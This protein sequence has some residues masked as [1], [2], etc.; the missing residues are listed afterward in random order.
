MEKIDC[1]Y[2]SDAS[3]IKGKL[4]SVKIPD[5]IE[6]VQKIIKKNNKITI[7]GA[8]TGLVGGC[9]PENSIVL[10]LSKF[11]NIK[12]FENNC[13]WVETGVVLDDLN[14]FLAERNFEFPIN[15]S[16]HSVCTIG[17][18]IANNAAGSRAFVYGKTL[19]WISELKVILTG[20][21]IKIIKE[22]DIKDFCSFEGINGVIIEAKLKLSPL[23]KRTISLLNFDSLQEILNKTKEL[24]K[25]KDVSKIE[26]W[27][28]KTS[29]ILKLDKKYF[30]LIEFESE[31]GELSEIK[32][33]E[34]NELRDSVYPRLAQAGFSKIED[35][36]IN[37][38]DFLELA[39]FLEKKKVPFFGHLS[40]GILHPCFDW[41]SKIEINDLFNLVRKVGGNVS[42]EHGIGR[43]KKKFL[44]KDEIFK[45]KRI[46]KEYDKNFKFNP[47][48]IL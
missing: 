44:N 47:G 36:Q 37:L 34:A 7:R 33:K 22:K 39:N 42:G 20:G 1:A 46:K 15:P 24:R 23:K 27:D 35:P 19:N 9:V 25:E 18:M 45:Y 8:G 4:I 30:L 41:N 12:N 38:D 2:F 16:S 5:S 31:K 28:K 17:G 11:N 6:E 10:D 26:F 3:Q 32:G 40:C 14:D 43:T 21:K 29:E 48:V 13:I